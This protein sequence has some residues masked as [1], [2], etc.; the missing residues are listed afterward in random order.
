MKCKVLILSAV[1]MMCLVAQGQKVDPAWE[2][3]NQRGYPEWFRDA[4]LGIFIHWGL[5]SVPA[6]ASPE[7]Y[8]EWFY[9]GLMT[10]DSGRVEQMKYYPPLS[11]KMP[12]DNSTLQQ[13]ANL[14]DYWHAEQWDPK[15]WADLFKESGAQYVLLVT[16]HHDGYCLWDYPHTALKDWNSVATGPKRN[17]VEELTN[18]VRAAGLKMGFYYSL[19][20]WTNPIHTW[21]VSPNDSIGRYVDTYMIPQ[22]KDLVSKYKPS[23]IFTD[24][25]WDNNAEQFK[26]RELISWYYNTVGPEA[27]VNDRWGAGHQHGFRTPEYSGGIID[28]ITPWAECRGVGR[29]F[30]VNH[31]EKLE[32]FISS[33]ALIQH[34]VQLVAAGG[35]LTLN[36]GPE[37]DGSIPYLQQERLA[38]LGRWMKINGEAIYGTRPWIKLCDAREKLVLKTDDA[39]DFDW[40]RNA[41]LEG[42][43]YDNFEIMWNG[44]IIPKYSEKYTFEVEVDDNA[45]V[46]LNED[47]IINHNKE[48]ANSSE[49]NAQEAANYGRTTATVKLKKGAEYKIKVCYEE[50]DLEARIRLRWQSKSQPKEAITAARGFRG[51]YKWKVPYACYTKKGK[52]LY[53]IMLETPNVVMEF[54]NMIEPNGQISGYMLYA[55]DRH[56]RGKYSDGTL[57]VKMPEAID[58]DL[59]RKSDGA[60]VLK[61]ENYLK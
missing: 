27:V 1:V 35:G 8:G 59:M 45:I 47:T 12:T 17:I 21:T 19:T 26:A 5:Y 46:I 9:R 49:S 38:D 2:S 56:V 48:K 55:P 34:F 54:P 30:G 51:E 14:R 36:V 42:M 10:G 23:L 24:G 41:P 18:T 39:I 22:F 4:K 11:T 7:G 31:N 28:T 52:D 61:L 58:Y 40:V 16:K 44:E 37:A 20:E 29:S 50:K 15:Q 13:Y 6:Y 57:Y 25:E 32:N 3:I 60:W 33:S 43:S 53:I